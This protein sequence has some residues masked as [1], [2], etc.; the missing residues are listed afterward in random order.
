MIGLGNAALVYIKQAE[1]NLAK[2][3]YQEAGQNYLKAS[4]FYLEKFKKSK[5]SEDGDFYKTEAERLYNEGMKYINGRPAGKN[6][7]VDGAGEE[8]QTEIS[9]SLSNVSFKNVAGMYDLKKALEE[10]IIWPITKSDIF[11]KALNK[12]NTGLI[13]YGPPG[14]G[15]TFLVEAAVGEAAIRSNNKIKFY[16]IKISD[17]K[18]KWV[19]DSEKNLEACFKKAASNEPSVLFFDELDALG[20]FRDLNSKHSYE[21]V[22]A[23]PGFWDY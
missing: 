2:Q 22:N 10:Y 9:E 21:L 13:L 5:N 12:K 1:E 14:C 4:E 3:N 20:G 6:K 17:V 23:F 11:D 7:I 18:S 8:Q 19:G 16:N 15:K